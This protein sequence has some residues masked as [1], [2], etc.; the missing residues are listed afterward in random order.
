MNKNL[1]LVHT[2]FQLMNCLNIVEDYYKDD[3]NH[4]VLLHRNM[5]KYL[6]II[7]KY[8]DKIHVYHYDFLFDDYSKSNKLLIKTSLVIN[9]IKGKRSIR[10]VANRNIKYDSLF[11]PSENIGCNIT[12]NYFY[13]LNN[14]LELF[15]YDD[16][17]GT[18]AKGYLKG[19]NHFLYEKISKLLYGTFFWEKLK[20]IFCYQPEF[21]DDSNLDI[22]KVK[23][24][25]T[26][27]IEKL[28][29]EHLDDC[30]INKYNMSKII[31]LDQGCIP[32]SYEN[33]KIFIEL[34]KKYY[35]NNEVVLKNHPRVSPVYESDSFE[36]D[37]SG[38]TFESVFFNIDIDEKVLVSMCSTS[39]LT[40][41]ILKE[42]YPYI[43]FLGLMNT[44][45]YENVFSTLYFRNVISNYKPNKIFIPKNKD[46]LESVFK[47]LS[48][49]N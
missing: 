41:Y 38:N 1:Y 36:K 11:I 25:S 7:R 40:P 15:V 6:S 9:L 42:K 44:N 32:S 22:V 5:K 21:I 34:C 2:P 37:K 16:G 26:E 19:K 12:Y 47:I 43:I 48:S 3:I 35:R 39:C 27:V 20:K 10:K 24:N 31:Y 13:E 49:K 17:V 28:F 4:I 30:L 45:R 33:T 23:I 46:E 8:N 29:S 14:S 18:Y